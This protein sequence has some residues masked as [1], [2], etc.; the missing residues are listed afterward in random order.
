MA[1]AFTSLLNVEVT[2]KI[3]AESVDRVFASYKE[4]NDQNEVLIQPMLKNVVIPSLVLTRDLDTGS[5]YYVVNY[6]DAS[7]H[8]DTVTGGQESK[9][10]IV[11][12]TRPDKL[13]S[14]RMR[15]LISSANALE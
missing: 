3:I 2:L 10:V 6:D 11:H 7:G 5:P 4:N 14:S 12:R 15:R 8:T 13:K 9:T 1:G